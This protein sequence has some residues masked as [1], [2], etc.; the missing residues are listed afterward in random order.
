MEDTHKRNYLE[1]MFSDPGKTF[2]KILNY[3]Q[4]F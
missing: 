1:F 3:I 4:K 2:V